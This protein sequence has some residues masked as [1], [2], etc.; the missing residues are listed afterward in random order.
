MMNT[1]AA[2]MVAGFDPFGLEGC[3]VLTSTAS[4]F[5]ERRQ[6]VGYAVPSRWRRRGEN[7]SESMMIV[8]MRW[9]TSGSHECD[10]IITVKE[11]SEMCTKWPE[12]G[13]NL[14]QKSASEICIALRTI[15]PGRVGREPTNQLHAAL[16]RSI[17]Y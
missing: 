8:V 9:N 11:R 7:T 5:Q 12:F 3:E 1:A 4:M 15:S 16:P 17:M 10:V 6:D 14:H 2:L 13:Y